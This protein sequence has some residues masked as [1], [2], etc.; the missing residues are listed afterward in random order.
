MPAGTGLREAME[1]Y[2][3]FLKADD[4]PPEDWKL[5][6][7]RE[8]LRCFQKGTENWEVRP[9]DETGRVEVRFRVRTVLSEEAVRAG[10]GGGGE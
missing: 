1:G 10:R 9:P 5:E 4:P 7:V 6:Q 2:G 8:A 3:R